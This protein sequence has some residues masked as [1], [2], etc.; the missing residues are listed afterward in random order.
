[1]QRVAMW[2][3]PMCPYAWMTSRWLLEV[4]PQREM[5]LSFHVM[6]L[7]VLNK[8][9]TDPSEHRAHILEV[10]WAPVRVCIAA[11]AAHGNA[12]LRD[13]YTALGNRIHVED[14][15]PTTDLITEALVEAGLPV[16]LV[17]AGDSTDFDEALV[18]SHNAGM[19]PVG[20]DVGTPIIHVT[21]EGHDTVAFFGPVVIPTPRGESAASLFDG[22]V[23][24]A[25]CEDFFELKRTRT[26]EPSFD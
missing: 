1:M 20:D 5:E 25:A 11:E 6:S 3:D 8:D 14:R 15:T 9:A 7:A 17:E 23:Q 24:V 21:P 10:G 26:R 18:A 22:V 16:S 13:L 4:E 2:F 12:C 19:K